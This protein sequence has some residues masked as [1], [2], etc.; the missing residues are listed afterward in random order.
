MQNKHR[1]RHRQND[2]SEGRLPN[3]RGTYLTGT[4]QG[5]ASN[6]FLLVDHNS[7]QPPCKSEDRKQRSFLRLSVIQGHHICAHVIAAATMSQCFVTFIRWHRG[8]F[9]KPMTSMQS[10]TQSVATTRAGMN[11][12]QYKRQRTTQ[13]EKE[14]TT[15]NA[16]RD[17]NDCP[18]DHFKEGLVKM[19]SLAQH[20][21]VKICYECKH[22]I[23]LGDPDVCTYIIATRLFR[24]YF[25]RHTRVPKVSFVKEWV[26]FH[27][28]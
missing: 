22:S 4:Q 7:K 5:R 10:F 18:M 23:W 8:K 9:P 3:F 19:C 21:Q 16:S 12:S 26:Y 14:N 24:Q 27:I 2:V 28:G 13:R 1:C 20:K 15:A 17:L 25:C 6:L 11:D